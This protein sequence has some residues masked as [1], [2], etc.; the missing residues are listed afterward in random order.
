MR[1]QLAQAVTTALC[2]ERR[3]TV[4]GTILFEMDAWGRPP[5][6]LRHLLSTYILNHPWKDSEAVPKPDKRIGG[7]ATVVTGPGFVPMGMEPR[8][9]IN[10]PVRLRT[11]TLRRGQI[12]AFETYLRDM[13]EHTARFARRY[14]AHAVAYVLV[15]SSTSSVETAH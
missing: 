8:N 5:A 15:V 9:F 13:T 1:T 4:E 2:G 12:Y 10:F 11:N 6:P 14:G 7:F 3:Y